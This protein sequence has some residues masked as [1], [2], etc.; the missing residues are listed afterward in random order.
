MIVREI[1]QRIQSLYSKGV[2]SDDSRLRPRH[3]YNK[4]LTVR[5]RL[6]YQKANK[7]QKFSQWSYQVIPCIEMIPADRHE[8]PC[9]P[10]P[11][12]KIM[13]SKHPLPKPITDI[14]NH[15]IQNV[16]SI[17]GSVVYSETSWNEYKYKKG[18]KYT[19]SI[20][21]YYIRNGHLFITHNMGPDVIS[22]EGIWENPL[23]A[24]QFP[25]ACKGDENKDTCISPLDMEFPIDED[26]LDVLIEVSVQE[27]I[28]V[29]GQ[30][31][32]DHYNNSRDDGRSPMP[33][34]NSE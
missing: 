4:M 16:T 29:F 7:K 14:S 33:S 13:K 15:L 12:C 28:A 11:G 10:A 25:S 26:L 9:I 23:E 27:L 2:Q 24:S 6:V 22:I 1:I 3:I 32:Q 8:C 5:S 19:K 18:N 30:G 34:G 17:D 31:I 21:D 20:P